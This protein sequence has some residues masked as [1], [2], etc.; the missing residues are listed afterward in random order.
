MDKIWLL[1]A[2]GRVLRKAA[3][4]A[5]GVGNGILVLGIGFGERSVLVRN[6]LALCSQLVLCH[7]SNQ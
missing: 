4:R 7:Q 2:S 3:S 6:L 1:G 5:R